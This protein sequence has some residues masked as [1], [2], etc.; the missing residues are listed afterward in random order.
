MPNLSAFALYLSS[1]SDATSSCSLDSSRH[2]VKQQA[3]AAA[4][5]ASYSISSVGV[6][7]RRDGGAAFQS[8]KAAYSL[9]RRGRITG[10][11]QEME[12]NYGGA[13]LLVWSHPNLARFLRSEA[14]HGHR[15]EER[16]PLPSA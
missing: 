7:Q 8:R 14:L 6:D 3:S 1:Q 5:L 11:M 9:S 16:D 10:E 13:P 4:A 2:F 12:N 15:N